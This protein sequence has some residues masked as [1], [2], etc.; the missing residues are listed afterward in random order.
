MLL[1]CWPVDRSVGGQDWA[2]RNVRS[3]QDRHPACHPLVACLR[4]DGDRQISWWENRQDACPALAQILVGIYV[5]RFDQDEVESFSVESTIFSTATS[6]PVSAFGGPAVF[7]PTRPCPDT[8]GTPAVSKVRVDQ[9][10]FP[11][12]AREGRT[13]LAGLERRLFPI[14]PCSAPGQ[15]KPKTSAFTKQP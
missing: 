8:D 13:R 7:M 10:D 6:S 2:P 15:P 3:K 9:Q 12:R 14:M 4:P 5:L 11:L 1:S